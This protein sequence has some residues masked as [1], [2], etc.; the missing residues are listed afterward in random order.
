MALT[1]PTTQPAPP[2]AITPDL[3]DPAHLAATFLGLLKGDDYIGNAVRATPDT[4]PISPVAAPSQPVQVAADTN[5]DAAWRAGHAVQPSAEPL[6]V[7]VQPD[8]NT[9]AGYGGDNL[10]SGSWAHDLLSMMNLPTTFENVKL[11]T[12]WQKI[13]GGGSDGPSHT[14][15]NWLN[16]NRPMP[17]STTIN[18][19]GVRSFANYHDG[20]VATAGALS[21][22]LYGN[23]LAAMAKGNDA[24]AVAQAIQESPW[25][26]G[27]Y[28]GSA[29]LRVLGE[30]K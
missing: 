30:M 27:H 3:K 29:L 21:N 10:H 11:L 20:L 19:S 1:L 7:A 5:A 16:T 15:F 24:R 17:G 12:A 9:P 2:K 8:S 23:V 4:S 28:A 18:S 13:E 22:G 26:A 25:D 6:K 14:N